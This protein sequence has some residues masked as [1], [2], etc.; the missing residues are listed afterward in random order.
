M[1]TLPV[2]GLSAAASA[3]GVSSLDHKVLDDAVE[4]GVVVVAATRQLRDV[5]AGP[6]RVLRV[7]LHSKVALLL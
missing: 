5:P 4:D 6:G 7:Q 1:A 3:R 2:D